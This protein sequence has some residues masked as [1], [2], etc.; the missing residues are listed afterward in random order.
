MY[1][2]KIIELNG[3]S[4]SIYTVDCKENHV[5]TGSGDQYVARWNLETGTQDNF[6]IRCEQA[7]Y[8]I[9]LLANLPLLCIGTSS[10]NFH[11]IDL[12]KRAEIKNFT[13]HKKAIF[14]MAESVRKNHFYVGD[15]D[16]NLSVWDNRSWEMLLFLP[17]ETGKIRCIRVSDDE[18]AIYL[19]CQDGNVRKFDTD[20]FNETLCWQTHQGGANCLIEALDG[21]IFTA[22]KD[23]YIRIW[24]MENKPVLLR[25]IPAHNFGIYQLEWINKQQNMISV[26][27]DKSIKIWDT[28]QMRVLQ[29][30]ERKKGGHSHAVNALSK[31]NETRFVTVGDDKRLIYWEL[32][33]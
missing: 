28:Q 30:L 14:S 13:A 26:S 5:Y 3:H 27:R 18:T 6:S 12:E 25:Q 29:K 31:V 1:V 8:K 32:I 21:S 22:G 11:V 10:G 16:G 7:V 33:D 17:L 20:T 15:A 2:E 19:A 23:G 4:A 9:K 24:K